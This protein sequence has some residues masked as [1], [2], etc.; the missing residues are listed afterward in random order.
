M[1][2]GS[3]TQFIQR[4][5]ESEKAHTPLSV[6]TDTVKQSGL[7]LV[8]HMLDELLARSYSIVLVCTKT[9]PEKSFKNIIAGPKQSSIV[10]VDRSVSFGPTIETEKITASGDNSTKGQLKNSRID[11]SEIESQIAKS[12]SQKGKKYAIA[13]DNIDRMLQQSTHDTL[14]LLRNLKQKINKDQ[15]RLIALYSIPVSMS[16]QHHIQNGRPKRGTPLVLN[17]L[18]EL[19]NTTINVLPSAEAKK[20]SPLTIVDEEAERK[21]G[22]IDVASNSLDSGIV[23]LEHKK[24]S[25][26]VVHESCF[27]KYGVHPT[28]NTGPEAIVGGDIKTA[29]WHFTPVS[30]VL[31]L[32]GVDPE[33]ASTKDEGS[34]GQ[35]QNDP[36]LNLSFNLKLTDEQRVAKESVELPYLKTDEAQLGSNRVPGQIIYQPDEGDDWD[37]DDPDDDLEI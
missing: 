32:T 10:V 19:A 27:Y 20:W 2:E 12:I 30:D 33:D 4:L 6:I 14:V 18:T 29:K 26:K 35:N 3:E 22:W 15:D 13:F 9:L 7:P 25:G 11:F 5:I 34:A 24:V 16:L 8:E 37:E 28:K 36:T 1:G 21:K 23:I 17:S 31:E